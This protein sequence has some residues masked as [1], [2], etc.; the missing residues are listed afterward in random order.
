MA[1]VEMPAM[2][3]YPV[4]AESAGKL[5]HHLRDRWEALVAQH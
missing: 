5:H 1:A 4:D 3:A 2:P